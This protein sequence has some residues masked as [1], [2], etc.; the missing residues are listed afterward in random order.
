VA[1]R[2]RIIVIIS[3]KYISTTIVQ[4]AYY[5]GEMSGFEGSVAIVRNG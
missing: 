5:C 1:S 4:V 2:Y 3:T